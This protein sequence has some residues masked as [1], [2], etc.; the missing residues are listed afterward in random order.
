MD[1]SK[2]KTVLMVDD[3]AENIDVLVGVLGKKYKIQVALNGE[4]A[5]N[6]WEMCSRH[7]SP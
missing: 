5:E 3:S 1:K 4:S 6:N 7:H 2:G